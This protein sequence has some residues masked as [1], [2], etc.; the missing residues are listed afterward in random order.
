MQQIIAASRNAHKIKEMNQILSSLGLSVISRDDAGIPPFEVEEDGETFEEN[1]FKKANEIMKVSGLPA[2][3]DDSGLAVDYL[4]GAPG[5]FSARFAGDECDDSKNNQKLLQ[6]LEGVPYE[7][8][9]ARFVCVMTLVYPDGTVLRARGECPGHIA[10]EE[11][12]SNGFGYDPLFIP[13]GYQT[14]FGHIPP[15]EKNRISHRGQALRKL[16]AMLEERENGRIL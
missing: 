1:S 11:S 16:A 12:G 2:V 4:D 8:R 9:T 6:L 3:A 14:S 15:E 7:Q 5:V 13:D 10:G